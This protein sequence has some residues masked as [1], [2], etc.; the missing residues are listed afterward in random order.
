LEA[1]VTLEGL[2]HQAWDEYVAYLERREGER[3][4]GA[5]LTAPAFLWRYLSNHGVRATPD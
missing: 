4:D 1:R 5:A 2:V 3:P